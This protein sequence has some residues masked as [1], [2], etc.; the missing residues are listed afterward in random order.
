MKSLVVLLGLA[1]AAP[2]FGDIIHLKDGSTL[3]GELQRTRDGWT[4][5]DA[6]GKTTDVAATDVKSIELKKAASHESAE[7]QL[8]SLRRSVVT[9]DDIHL[10]LKHYQDFLKQNAGSPAAAEAQKDV[11]TWQDRLD[12][13]LVRAGDQWVTPEQHAALQAQS[14]QAAKAIVPLISSGRLTDA[15]AALNKAL[16]ITPKSPQLLYLKG[17]VLLRQNQLVPARK[18]FQDAEA[19]EPNNGPIHNNIAVILWKTHNPMPALAEYDKAMTALPDNQIILDNVAEALHAL[20]EVHRKNALTKR[21]VEHFNEQDAALQKQMSAKGLYRWGAQW[22]DKDAY[23]QLQTAQKAAQEKVDEIKKQFDDN[24]SRIV[25]IANEITQDQQLMNQM[26]QQSFV[27]DP[28]SGRVVAMPLPQRYY[29][30]QRDIQVLQTEGQ[31]KQRQQIEL[32]RLYN[33]RQKDLPA[34]HYTGNQKPFDAE[35]MPGAS[36]SASGG[37]TTKPA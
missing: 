18:A 30:L 33:E 9:L 6:N 29:D 26:Q 5:T 22:L 15:S 23:S 12:K 24:Q 36:Q 20:P 35:G 25:Q 8:E 17:V 21:V 31:T 7:Q 19:A 27:Q 28:G 10:I 13:G 14:A 34:Q 11:A 16:A 37:A 4:V 32:Q 1:L 2:A 3:E